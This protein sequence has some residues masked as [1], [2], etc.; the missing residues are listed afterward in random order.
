MRRKS[1]RRVGNNSIREIMLIGKPLNLSD[2]LFSSEK[3]EKVL[4]GFNR[5][6]RM[7]VSPLEGSKAWPCVLF[8][9]SENHLPSSTQGGFI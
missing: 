2:W 9:G 5:Q 1:L 4:E 8:W 7:T 6:P 3:I